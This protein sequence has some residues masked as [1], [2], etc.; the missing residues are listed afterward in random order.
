MKLTEILKKS[1]S[2]TLICSVSACATVANSD[3]VEI[4]VTTYPS[5]ATLHIDGRVYKSPAIVQVKRGSG[6]K[7]LNI[8]SEGYG[9]T[10]VI[11][12]QSYDIWML[13]NF[14]FSSLFF[15]GMIV[16]LIS[17][18]GYDIEPEIVNV[19]LTNN[20]SGQT[21]QT[22]MQMNAKKSQALPLRIQTH[23]ENSTW[24]PLPENEMEAA[25]RDSLLEKLSESGQFTFVES[26][27]NGDEPEVGVLKIE[28]SL[29]ESIQTIK[30]TTKL[31]IPG[32]A[33]HIET[34]SDSLADKSRKEIYDIF[35]SLGENA[36]SKLKNKTM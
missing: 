35:R 7:I 12:K 17:G 16:D 9:S 14:G 20:Q 11:L 13:A 33:T 27:R 6:N 21:Q 1:L 4:P 34:E 2:M 28:M 19:N 31:Q 32:G 3:F 8:S 36:G 26:E 23:F 22:S 29:I 25:I 18:D 24:F 30:V 15:V 10:D 5:N